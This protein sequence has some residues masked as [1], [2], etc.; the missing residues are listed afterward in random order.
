MAK[1]TKPSARAGF[2]FLTSLRHSFKNGGPDV[3]TNKPPQNATFHIHHSSNNHSYVIDIFDHSLAIKIDL[4]REFKRLFLGESHSLSQ[5]AE[6]HS[7][8]REYVRRTLANAGVTEFEPTR[9]GYFTGTVP[10]GWKKLNGKLVSHRSEQ[11]VITEMNRLRI[12]GHSLRAIAQTLNSKGL[13]TKEAK[14][15]HS[16]SVKRTLAQNQKI[17]QQ[18]NI[19]E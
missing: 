15:W 8:S 18:P 2:S 7:V 1:T 11:R 5:I 6:R 14:S 17:T 19:E 13:K 4:A 12:C 3:T 16:Q 9:P 10:F